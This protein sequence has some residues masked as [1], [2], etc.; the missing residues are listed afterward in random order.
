METLIDSTKSDCL[1]DLT[2]SYGKHSANKFLK[3]INEKEEVLGRRLDR[4]E[5]LR[6]YRA[7]DDELFLM[8]MS[9]RGK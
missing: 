3:T 6:E 1:T 9:R 5:I 8:L 2:M 7:L 4:E